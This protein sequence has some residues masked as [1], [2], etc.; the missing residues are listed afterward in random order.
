MIMIVLG[1]VQ[2]GALF[3]QGDGVVVMVSVIAKESPA[4]RAGIEPGDILVTFEGEKIRRPEDVKRIWAQ[5]Y[6]KESESPSGGT[7]SFVIHRL[8]EK[9]QEIRIDIPLK[10]KVLGFRVYQIMRVRVPLFLKNASLFMTLEKNLI[11]GTQHYRRGDPRSAL[12]AWTTALR[13]AEKLGDR[14]ELAGHCINVGLI[15][16]ALREWRSGLAHYGRALALSREVKDRRIEASALSGMGIARQRLGD[17]K[18]AMASYKASSEVYRALGNPEGEARAL[19]NMGAIHQ[20]M[21][22]YP[23][24]LELMTRALAIKEK[25]NEQTGMEMFLWNIGVVYRQMGE[26]EK[27]IGFFTRRLNILRA[28]GNRK[29]EA[30][31]LGRIGEEYSS[32]KRHGKALECRKKAVAIYQ[33]INDK[34]NVCM[35]TRSLGVTL[36]HMGFEERG[37]GLQEE[38]LKLARE[39]GDKG[40]EAANL[41]NIGI[42]H[43]RLHRYDKAEAALVEGLALARES[44]Q[45]QWELNALT[46]TADLYRRMGRI[47]EAEP[48][49]IRAAKEAKSD[50]NIARY[51]EVLEQIAKVFWRHGWYSR[52]LDYSGRA[53]QIREE[54]RIGGDWAVR[55]INMGNWYE[56]VGQYEM[57]LAFYRKG[58]DGAR[59]VGNRRC[60]A[61]A[62]SNMGMTYRDL[63]MLKEALEHQ[64]KA[65]A[66][67]EKTGDKRGI[68]YCFG[69]MGSTYDYM[70][71]REKASECFAK[72][73]AL[74]REIGDRAGLAVIWGNLGSLNWRRRE[75]AEAIRCFEEG[76]KIV[77]ELGRYKEELYWNLALIFQPGEGKAGPYMHK[78]KF[79]AATGLFLAEVEKA[80]RIGEAE[81]LMAKFFPT[82][83]IALDVAWGEGKEET[84]RVEGEWPG[85]GEET[86]RELQASPL[87]GK[88]YLEAGFRW[89]ETFRAREFMWEMKRKSVDLEKGVEGEALRARNE[90]MGRLNGLR[91]RMVRLYSGGG[92]YDE[93]GKELSP[94]AIRDR[95]ARLRKA[96]DETLKQVEEANRKI[97]VANPAQFALKAEAS[98]QLKELQE[99]LGENEVFLEF[100]LLGQ[101]GKKH[102]ISV[103]RDGREEKVVV[104]RLEEKSSGNAY[105]LVVTRKK[106]NV[107]RLGQTEAI[108]NA[109]ECF[110]M[111]IDAQRWCSKVED[112]VTLGRDLYRCLVGRLIEEIGQ[113]GHGVKHIILCPDGALTRLP[114]EAL[115]TQDVDAGVK[116]EAL[117]YLAKKVS[118]EYTSS[119]TAWVH[120]RKG[121]FRR[122][123][124]GKGFVALADP[125]Y[126]EGVREDVLRSSG[127]VGKFL[128]PADEEEEKKRRARREALME[129]LSPEIREASLKATRVRGGGV[130]GRLPGTREEVRG[131]APLFQEGWTEKEAITDWAEGKTAPSKSGARVYLGRAAREGIARQKSLLEDAEVLHFACHGIADDLAPADAS[132]IL[133]TVGVPEDED[134]FLSA[135]EVMALRTNARVVVLSACETGLGK[136]IR[137]EGVQGLT[138]AWQYAGART[139][140]VSLWK[141][142]DK[143]TATFMRHFYEAYRKQGLKVTRALALAKRHMITTRKV[144]APVYWAAFTAH[145]ER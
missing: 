6:A 81:S 110:R 64:K 131:I 31:T 47:Q 40:E 87:L 5:L 125:D 134:G 100:V 137:G 88:T 109:V 90:L 93:Q 76:L 97:S 133:T 68:S 1:F 37:L 141:V 54:R 10:E 18:G 23:Q 7:C 11:D 32:L 44:G 39:I 9:E 41:I 69:R 73:L 112:F 34:R 95:S 78:G 82:L 72:A 52:A 20:R 118:T 70:K 22:R 49:L 62:L 120:M 29:G 75:D 114:F 79:M 98:V 130:L 60:E 104:S 145:G 35:M 17:L 63:G 102:R 123:E 136:I 144:A 117:P 71:E 50:R 3:A 2:G 111:A 45:K 77:R 80:M 106:A 55:Y 139:V 66:L 138:R 12:R 128:S 116:F 115:V 122:G 105:G 127:V 67:M 94:E 4:E 103:D 124:P 38:A 25:H 19:G 26:H 83:G 96:F 140:I 86:I 135:A 129:R 42:H 53:F 24:A 132:I 43:M 21:G 74:R 101:E 14:R 91:K 61:L 85:M 59:A 99:T 30:D 57:A 8:G 15:S 51:V 92:V 46:S 16:N 56:K 119:A 121:K 84:I 48:I 107:L 27:A 33:A 36:S 143:A 89:V 113:E 108:G 126:G 28:R 142:D 13:C 58:Y 65:L